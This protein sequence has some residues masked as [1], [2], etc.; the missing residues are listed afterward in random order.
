MMLYIP[1]VGYLESISREVL[2]G[3]KSFTLFY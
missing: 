2:L 1:D 3:V